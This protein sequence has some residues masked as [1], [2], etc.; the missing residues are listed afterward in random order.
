MIGPAISL[1]HDVVIGGNATA[2]I[3]KIV[4]GIIR[5]NQ[6]EKYLKQVAEHTGNIQ[7]DVKRLSDNV[8]YAANLQAV[9]D[10][11]QNQQRVVDNLKKVRKSLKPLSQVTRQEI[12][13]SAMIQTP[14][15]MQK[16]MHDNPW[17]VLQYIRPLKH[18]SSVSYPDM[19]PVL[20]E[21]PDS[22]VQYIGWQK[23]GMLLP[24]F[25]CK[26]K[27][28]WTPEIL[29]AKPT[30]PENQISP[31]VQ[32][33]LEELPSL[34]NKELPS[35][36]NIDGWSVDKIQALQKHTAQVLDL[37][38]PLRDRLTDNGEGPEMMVIPAGQLWIGSPGSEISRSDS[39][40]QHPVIIRQPFAI[41]HYPVIFEE[42]DRFCEA[43]SS[44]K[45]LK[46]Y[47]TYRKPDDKGWGRGK[48]PVIN[49]TWYEAMAYAQWL[50]EQT[51]QQYRLPTEAEWEYAARAGTITSFYFGQ[52]ITKS[53]VN[54]ESSQTMLVGQF[55]P[56]AWGLHDMHGNVWEW[57]CS[58]YNENYDGSELR[59]AE[60]GNT[61]LYRVIRGGGWN[62]DAGYCRSACRSLGDPGS[63]RGNLGFRLVRQ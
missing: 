54:Y 13:S 28:I 3:Y 26:Y 57:T 44:K 36:E 48:R 60:S 14:D 39:E 32:G 20:F 37:P 63:R 51:G 27:E 9:Q 34:E 21:D 8:L 59:C 23:R 29:P 11:T 53:Q 61:S 58:I 5:G 45:L 38:L 42:Y 30:S 15:K 6:T 19:V 49:I 33:K 35:L 7:I 1:F 22:H 41:G 31:V 10:V 56:N 50:S 40:R 55:Q 46:T 12:L 16:T 4:S 18:A 25:D 52:N 43:T 17:D 24:A 47:E 62:D 2:N